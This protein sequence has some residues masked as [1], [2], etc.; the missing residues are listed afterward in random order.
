QAPPPLL[1]SGIIPAPIASL[2]NVTHVLPAQAVSGNHHQVTLC[3]PP[4]GALPGGQYSQ[5]PAP[6]RRGHSHS[7]QLGRVEG[8]GA[9]NGRC[10]VVS[11]VGNHAVPHYRYS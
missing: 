10:S 4:N 5:Y 3:A 11:A 1:A 8:K 6:T 9:A 2:L 7:G